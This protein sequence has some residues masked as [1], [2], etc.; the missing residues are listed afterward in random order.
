[1]EVIDVQRRQ[2]VYRVTFL[3]RELSVFGN[4]SSL[5]KCKRVRGLEAATRV[6]GI[7][8]GDSS[9]LEIR[10]FSQVVVVSACSSLDYC[11]ASVV[12][13]ILDFC[14]RRLLVTFLL[15]VFV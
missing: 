5:R 15:E 6:E 12:L 10:G 2:G 13:S 7:C 14:V 1:M 11:L 3:N 9:R 4:I 8:G